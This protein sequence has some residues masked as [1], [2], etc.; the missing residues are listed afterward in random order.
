VSISYVMRP[1]SSSPYLCLLERRWRFP[2][3]NR[4]TVDDRPLFLGAGTVQNAA[5]P[6]RLRQQTSATPVQCYPTLHIHQFARSLIPTEWL[7]EQTSWTVRHEKVIGTLFGKA[8]RVALQRALVLE[9]TFG[10]IVG[11]NPLYPCDPHANTQQEAMPN[12]QL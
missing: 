10:E 6:F 2:T 11:L 12:A 5:D 8:H 7:Y 4:H 3:R 9:G 1:T